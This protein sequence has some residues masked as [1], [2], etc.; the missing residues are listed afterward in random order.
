MKRVMTVMTV[1]AGL[2]LMTGCVGIKPESVN[3]SFYLSYALVQSGYDSIEIA[4]LGGH[5]KT[6]VQANQLKKPL[7]DLKTGLDAAKVAWDAGLGFDEGIFTDT[8]TTLR[9]LQQSLIALGAED[10]RPTFDPV[11]AAA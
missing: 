10:G 2:L 1:L 11:G 3:Q 4:I 5:V 6:Q 7:D 9:L 8:Q